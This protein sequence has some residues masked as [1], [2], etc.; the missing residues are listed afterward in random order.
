MSGNKKGVAKRFKDIVPHSVF[1]HCYAH[2]LN[3]ALQDATNQFKYVSDILLIVQN[4]S[5]FVE[6]SAKR[7][8]FLSNYR[9]MKRKINLL[10]DGLNSI[11]HFLE[12]LSQMFKSD[13]ISLSS[14][15]NRQISSQN[16]NIAT[17]KSI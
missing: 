13:C 2:K 3:L 1:V 17:I 14:I 15:L 7:L 4:I 9:A 12:K 8:I 5:V 11:A 16:T 10:F 6:R